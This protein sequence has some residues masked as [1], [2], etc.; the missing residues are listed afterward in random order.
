M[1]LAP[2]KCAQITFPGKK[3]NFDIVGE[4][5]ANADAAK[6]LGIHIKDYLS[7]SKHIEERLRKANKVQYLL[8]R[9]VAVQVKALI[10]LGLYKSL[11]LPVL[12]YGFTCINPSRSELQNLEC[13]HKEAMKWITGNKG[14]NYISQLRLQ[15]SP[16][17]YVSPSERPT[18]TCESHA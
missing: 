8:R 9:N 11:I 14:V 16:L 6:D 5:L 4:D 2:D 10:K 1:E 13:F 3:Q 15:Y 18:S 12:L 7:W 17:A